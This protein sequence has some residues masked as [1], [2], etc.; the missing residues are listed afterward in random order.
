MGPVLSERQRWQDPLGIFRNKVAR[1]RYDGGRIAARLG[2]PR[3][4]LLARGRLSRGAEE[5]V[6]VDW[7]SGTGADGDEPMR[8]SREAR[9]R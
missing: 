9:W 1:Q 2:S 7:Y 3:L 4:L 5:R 8:A 6:G